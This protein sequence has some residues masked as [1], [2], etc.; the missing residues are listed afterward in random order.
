[1]V[2]HES[3]S[4]QELIT[5]GTANM[6]VGL[7]QSFSVS[8][9]LS[10]TPV[11]EAELTGATTQITGIVG[12]LCIILLLIFVP[13]LLQDLPLTALSAVVVSACLALFNCRDVLR[14]YHLRLGEFVQSMVCFLGVVL[15]GVI[16]GIFIAIGLALF[17][18][19]WRAWRPYDAILGRVD[20]LKGYHDI[21]R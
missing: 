4:N 19:I 12:A 9:S 17:A 16:Q 1:L 11:A 10:R 15:L 3:D 6:A 2:L 13:R 14:L 7:F 20:G 5:L 8:S 21:S 18:F